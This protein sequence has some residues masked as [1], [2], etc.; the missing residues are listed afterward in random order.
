MGPRQNK[1]R[2]RTVEVYPRRLRP[3]SNQCCQQQ[4]VYAFIS[5]TPRTPALSWTL[6]CLVSAF[7]LTS[8]SLL[9]GPSAPSP[10][11]SLWNCWSRLCHTC[12]DTSCVLTEVADSP[13][14]GQAKQNAQLNA[15]S[16]PRS[17]FR[18]RHVLLDL[19]RGCRRTF[20]NFGF[21]A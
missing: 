3:H 8:S 11:P 19:S 2:H 15:S 7:V 9:E 13:A 10:S 1:R 14:R 20:S 21:M 6:P 4:T 5:N 16:L 12:T 18:T 17:S